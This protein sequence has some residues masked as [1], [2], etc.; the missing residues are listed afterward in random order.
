MNDVCPGEK[1]AQS[2][3]EPNP[4]PVQNNETLARIAISS[5]H[6]DDNRNID[7]KFIKVGELRDGG[8]SFDRKEICGESDIHRRGVEREKLSVKYIGYMET[9]TETIRNI[10]DNKDRQEFCVLD[11]AT[12]DNKA[13]AI[14][15]I[16]AD[17]E[18]SK[19][20]DLR[21][22]LLSQMKFNAFDK[23]ANT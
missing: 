3:V 1:T 13:H 18:K 7:K 9:K 2:K 23:H 15:K 19:I 16:S 20:R 11:D 8:C 12:K 17:Q 21:N 10:R 14:V 22:K 5:Y 6:L 4:G